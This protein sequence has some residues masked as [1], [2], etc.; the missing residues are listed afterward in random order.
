MGHPF[1]D[2]AGSFPGVLDGSQVYQLIPARGQAVDVPFQE[3]RHFL[4]GQTF[5]VR[6]EE[7]TDYSLLLSEVGANLLIV[8]LK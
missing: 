5:G 6:E 7:P 3:L 2:S 8:R 4:I 1:G